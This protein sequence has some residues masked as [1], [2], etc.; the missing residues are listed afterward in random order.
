M[1][2]L[3]AKNILIEF[4]RFYGLE[5]AREKCLEEIEELKEV[6]NGWDNLRYNEFLTRLAEESAHVIVTVNKLINAYGISGETDKEVMETLQHL[7]NLLDNPIKE[8]KVWKERKR[9]KGLR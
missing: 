1:D 9:N 5:N 8:Q 3:Q 7:Q 6:I 4:N 2:K